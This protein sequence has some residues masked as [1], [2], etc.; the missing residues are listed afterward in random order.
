MCCRR[1][2]VLRAA[3]L[4]ELP[5][6]VPLD[7]VN[8][9]SAQHVVEPVTKVGPHVGFREV[10]DELVALERGH[11][12]AGRQDPVRVG[13]VQVRVR[14]HHLGLEPQ[15]EL[16]PESLDVL[17][18]GVQTIGPHVLVNPPVAEPRVVVA[19]PAKPTVVEYEAF[20]PHARGEIGERLEP[21]EVV[22]EVHRLPDIQSHQ[23]LNGMRREAALPGVQ[24][25]GERVQ[26]V[27]SGHNE[28]PRRGVA[29]AGLEH[30]LAGQQQLA[31]AQ[32]RTLRS[33]ALNSHGGVAARGNQ[34]ADHLAVVEAEA[35]SA[36][37]QQARRVDARFAYPRLPYPQPV[38]DLVAL[39]VPLVFVAPREVDKLAEVVGNGH[40]DLERVHQVRCL[41]D[42]GH[43]VPNAKCPTGKRLDLGTQSQTGS[44]VV[45]IDRQPVV[46]GLDRARPKSCRPVAAGRKRAIRTA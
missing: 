33:A 37:D 6:V 35:A 4:E 16:H 32:R 25:V 3:R 21:V 46:R 31:P 34:D 13:P 41:A 9:M 27:T 39:Q 45:G 1:A 24:A 2:V 43:G 44:R 23:L 8:A 29:L 10:E 38:S 20:H 40:R 42:V 12:P 30:H 26:P 36:G 14:V 7:V 5:V 18:Q 19:S 22:I 17:D 15:P 28:D 11:P